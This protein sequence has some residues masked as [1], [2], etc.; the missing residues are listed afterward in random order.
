M[1]T[2]TG[3]SRLHSTN[4]HSARNGRR[5][6]T[7]DAGDIEGMDKKNRASKIAALPSWSTANERQHRRHSHSGRAIK[8]VEGGLAGKLVRDYDTEEELRADRDELEA[9]IEAMASETPPEEN[10]KYEI[11]QGN[12]LIE[13]V[14]LQSGAG[15]N[16]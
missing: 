2:G 9:L 16:R 15:V 7:G 6:G 12:M 10:R 11:F 1:R 14:E 8:A 5:H 13:V 4:G 3:S